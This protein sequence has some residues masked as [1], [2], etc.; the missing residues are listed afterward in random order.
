LNQ[1]WLTISGHG[2]GQVHFGPFW[3]LITLPDLG[4]RFVDNYL[5][6]SASAA[7]DGPI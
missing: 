2:W 7:R 3:T 6:Q 1:P 5:A 4:P